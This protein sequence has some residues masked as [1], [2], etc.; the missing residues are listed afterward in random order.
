VR[1]DNVGA[2]A[3]YTRM[4]LARAFESRALRVPWSIVASRETLQDA[5]ILARA[6]T[7]E[8]DARVE[9]PMRL[10][11]GQL[12]ASRRLE[13][14]VL[15]GLFDDEE[16]LG[17]TVFDPSFPG[18][19]PFRVARP[20]LAV[21]LLDAL[22]PYARAT[23]ALINVVIEGQPDVADAL[24]AA[25]ATVKM[26]AVHMSSPTIATAEPTAAVR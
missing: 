17:A 4:G 16:V 10:L 5:R 25:G 6:I 22:R 24:V 9:P 3:L 23:D 19:Y 18:A 7:P 12:A 20:D 2:I 8:D 15:L 11:A 1:P 13:G 26:E 21:V 14:R